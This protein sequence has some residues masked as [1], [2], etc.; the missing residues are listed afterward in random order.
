MSYSEFKEK[1]RGFNRNAEQS[2]K[3][4]YRVINGKV[5]TKCKPYEFPRIICDVNDYLKNK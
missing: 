3:D 4:G 5:V 2:E 1:A